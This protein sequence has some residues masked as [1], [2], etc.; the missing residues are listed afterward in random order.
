M[1]TM[2]K[3]LL[4]VILVATLLFTVFAIGLTAFATDFIGYTPISTKEELNYYLNNYPSNN[5]YLTND[6]E[7]AP[8]DPCWTP[9]ESFSGILDGNGYSIKGL[10]INT[11]VFEDFICVG[12]INNMYGTI[13]NLTMDGCNIKYY[14]AETPD[15]VDNAAIY[16]GTIVGANYGTIENCHNSSN[17][18]ATTEYT[19]SDVFVGG[20]AGAN[21]AGYVTN[22]SNSGKLYS[23]AVCGG[24]VGIDNFGKITG[25]YN[26]TNLFGDYIYSQ[27]GGILGY[28]KNTHVS[29]CYNTG[30]IFAF[31]DIIDYTYTTTSGGIVAVL[32]DDSYVS[33]CYNT[34][35]VYA[36]YS[37]GGILGDGEGSIDR[38]FN[39]GTILAD[40]AAGGIA[41]TTNYIDI[42]NYITNCFNVGSIYA[43]T[44][45]SLYAKAGGIT[46]QNCS[47][48]IKY[49]YN[50]GPVIYTG[51]TSPS[52]SDVGAIA[53]Y[54]AHGK[55]ESCYY[56]NL[57]IDKGVDIA[58]DPTTAVESYLNLSQESTF[59]G[60]DFDNIWEIDYT[61]GYSFPILKGFD[62][63]GI[64][65]DWQLSSTDQR[66]PIGAPIHTGKC[67]NDLTWAMYN[68][69][70]LFIF[71]T[72]AMYDYSPSNPAP[73]TK[74]N[75]EKAVAVT[76]G[77]TSVG[78]YAFYNCDSI[79][80][81]L[82]GYDV[83]RIGES[84]FEGCDSLI[85]V[86]VHEKLKLVERNAFANCP[87]Y[88]ATEYIG[89]LICTE[90]IKVEDGND[91][92]RKIIASRNDRIRTATI[93]KQPSRTTLKY[94]DVIWITVDESKIPEGCHVTMWATSDKSV[95]LSEYDTDGDNWAIQT[96][97]KANG[98]LIVFAIVV[99]EEGLAVTNENGEFMIDYVE[100]QYKH[101]FFDIIGSFFRSLFGS[102]NVYR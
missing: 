48:T 97:G 58:I 66:A 102:V 85:N 28:G 90:G 24:I 80:S 8:S 71:G 83:E 68:S 65:L 67:G 37:C 52:K 35:L 42:K 72:G 82:L 101:S 62:Y 15:Y 12:M 25:C 76:N 93:L 73:W 10:Q 46:A 57:L 5:Y 44:D 19:S 50:V 20:I 88:T 56:Y 92:F 74:L 47:G 78:D 79:V 94:G 7:F 1:K 23:S 75:P 36:T 91:N 60:F 69:K 59:T 30:E 2:F 22:C 96:K 32:L 53:G 21:Y 38:C 34:G 29:K 3:K 13:R 55:Y 14:T 54:S 45:Y 81:I 18:Y 99:D 11:T 87:K 6:I 100:I 40:H 43:L 33:E 70:E 84:A 95:G 39:T 63:D 9:V 89:Q 49:C 41:G 17:I 98:T 16:I 26:T 77:A 64:G 51:T 4:S 86:V 31:Y 61:T 27:I